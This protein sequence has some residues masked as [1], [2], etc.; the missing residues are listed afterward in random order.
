MS[1][2]Y[3]VYYAPAAD[4][5]LARR[6]AAWLGRDAFSGEARER[7]ALAGL[8]G[9]DLEALTASPRAYGFHATLK[10]PFELAP[11][12]SEAELVAFG[13]A[14]AAG[15]E[16]F[17]APLAVASLGRF[18]AL[19]LAEDSPGMHA[20]HAACVRDFDPFRAPLSDFDLSRRRKAPL[21][22]E[23]DERLVAWGYPYV[24]DDFRFHMTLTDAVR[25]PDTAERLQRALRGHFADLEG[26]HRFD[27][28]ALFK[29][30]DRDAPFHVLARFGFGE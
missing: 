1:A 14:F 15:Q 4:D 20:L 29:Q 26:P 3:A 16:P 18:H 2:R 7:P 8:E 24:F 17:T 12:R 6:A 13:E 21:S 23:Q 30:D 19:R 5:P 28:V 9:L 25:D 11:D 22:A 10:A 27:S